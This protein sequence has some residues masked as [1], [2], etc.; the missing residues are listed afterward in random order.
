MTNEELTISFF[1][2][3]DPTL[4]SLR[5][6]S[7]RGKKQK[8]IVD[9]GASKGRK[10]RFVLLPPSPLPLPLKSTFTKQISRPRKSPKLYDS[11]RS[12]NVSRRTD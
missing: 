9:T 7:A 12:G 6:A 10:I 8:K 3:D 11:D 1:V 5:L 4:A 2:A